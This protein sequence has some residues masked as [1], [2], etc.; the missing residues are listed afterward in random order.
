MAYVNLLGQIRVGVRGAIVVPTITPLFDLYTSPLLAYSFRKLKS[1]Y[2]GSAIRVR[3]SNDNSELDISFNTD[4]SLNT[5]S[6]LDFTNPP[7]PV[8]L[9]L[10]VY[11]ASTAAYSIRKLTGSYSG[12]AIRVRRTPDDSEMDINFNADG[13][14]DTI[15]L[16]NFVNETMPS[17]TGNILDNYGTASAA[18]SLRRLR[19]GATASIRV[20]RTNSTN[21][22][23]NLETDIFFDANG[24][25][26]TT[27]LLAHCT[28]TN[29]FGYVTTWYD[30]SGNSKNVTQTTS[31]LQP[32]IVNSGSVNTQFGKPTLKFSGAYYLN[33]VLSPNS[34]SLGIISVAR[35]TSNVS[36]GNMQNSVISFGP[37]NGWGSVYKNI[38]YTW[39]SFRFGSGYGSTDTKSPTLTNYGMSSGAI[40]SIFKSGVNEYARVN[41]F[42]VVS[43]VAQGSS[44][45]N[46][47]TTLRVGA[48]V[49]GTAFYGDISEVIIYTG[50]DRS[51]SRHLIERHMNTYYSVFNYDVKNLYVSKWYDQSGYGKDLTN[52]SMYHPVIVN[53]GTL[54][55]SFGKPSIY[56]STT[57]NPLN[58]LKTPY[59]VNGLTGL[60]IISVSKV[61]GYGSIIKFDDLSWGGIWQKIST[62]GVEYRF[63]I[64]SSTQTAGYSVS[65]TGGSIFSIYKNGT[66]EIARV[67]GLDRA[68]YTSSG[69]TINNTGSIMNIGSD[70]YTGN[71]SEIIFYNSNKISD[72]VEMETNLNIYYNIYKNSAY[73]K[74]WY[75]QSGNGRNVQQVTAA[76]QPIIVQSGT[77]VTDNGLP[78]VKFSSAYFLS[79]NSTLPVGS[80]FSVFSVLRKITHSNNGGYF[81]FIPPSGNDYNSAGGRTFTHGPSL[82]YLRIE[83]VGTDLYYSTPGNERFVFSGIY[84]GTTM[85]SRISN[86]NL[87]NTTHAT[88]ISSNGL[89]LGARYIGGVNLI[90]DSSM[91][92]FIL[93]DS[94]QSVSRV[95]IENN[96]NSHYN[97]WNNIVS[98]GLVL[99]LDSGRTAS[100]SGTGNTWND[101][102]TSS[103]NGTL[104]NGVGYSSSNGGSLVF[105]GVN[106]RIT[107]FSSQLLATGSRTVNVWFK[108]NTN[109]VRQG[110]CGTRA[111]GGL[112]TGWVFCINRSGN[113]YLTYFNTG[114]GVLQTNASIVANT[115]Y[116]AVVTHSSTGEAK[117]YL[118]G[119]L[120]GTS[121][122]GLTN[123]SN[124]NGVIGD[125]DGDFGTPFKGNISMVNIYNKVLTDTEILQNFNQTRTRF[126]L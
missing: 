14:L 7:G 71:I 49:T 34:S 83:A 98:S 11:T 24:N 35:P 39:T 72:R 100:Y 43:Q 111:G 30:Q 29:N 19:T 63:G 106:D 109:T 94:N 81:T 69:T 95:G 15:T 102:S 87:V 59:T 18:Y 119:S 46:T 36:P 38:S 126:G 65:N 37:D 44:V 86:S 27:A 90:T 112:S 20:R 99:H 56:F 64:G 124:F 10:D 103:N 53:N 60:S 76:S 12:P 96:I 113:G 121:N 42:D 123:Q 84:S 26:D 107:S 9:I 3:R 40:T 79:Y 125:E 51:S 1:S 115:W 23:D 91:N 68:V 32:Q 66:Q 8:G 33:G 25:L 58:F 55:T 92:E 85:S 4:G 105:D 28:G 77:V 45:G 82:N 41:G 62:S 104:V 117:I 120:L 16:M 21:N 2:S 75:D 73:I 50:Y 61:V 48:G 110:L 89:V 78:S 80:T 17:V 5:Q 31:T 93:Y 97:L 70:G 67:N 54:Y 114:G 52:I 108:T 116:N 122:I 47:G 22:G 74:T 13:T 101:L 88:T 6:M 118:N 57:K